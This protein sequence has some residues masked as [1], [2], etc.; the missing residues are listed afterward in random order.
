[1]LKHFFLL[2]ASLL[3]AMSNAF[4]FCG[5]F[6]AKSDGKMFNKSSQVILARNGNKT[7]ITM[8]QD[9]QGD[10]KDF[11]MVVPVPVVL[12]RNQ[13]RTVESYFIDILNNYSAPRVAEYRDDSPCERKVY[14]R[15]DTNKLMVASMSETRGG[16]A[17][18]DYKVKIE[19]SYE[20]DEYD[21]LILSAKE[22]DGL[23]RWLVDNGYKI[24][25]QAKE[26]LEPYIKS[27]MKFFVAK[28]SLDR[29]EEKGTDLTPLQISF[30][31]KKFMLPIRLGMANADGAQ[32]MQ[33][34]VINKGGRVETTNYQQREMKSNFNIPEFASYEFDNFYKSL[35]DKT[36]ENSDK[37]GIYVE[38][39]WDL[40]QQSGVKCDPCVSPPVSYD[41]LG[42]FG[43][44]WEVSNVFFT[45]LRVRYDRD[46]FPQD[47][48][49]QITPNK[50]RFQCR[51]V[52][53]RTSSGPFNCAAAKDYF[54]KV[55]D[56]RKLEVA[57]ME[58]YTS[59]KHTDFPVY[60]DYISR[61]EKR[62]GTKKNE[63]LPVVAP[64]P[65]K[66][67]GNSGLWITLLFS[68]IATVVV[69]GAFVKRSMMS[70]IP[71]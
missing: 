55:T 69:G 36:Y 64:T 25:E 32:N 49:F 62:I 4:P 23:Q 68:M 17:E 54:K 38:Y 33:V 1:M 45:R 18:R 7:T 44:D 8:A 35:F 21:I 50:E 11:A 57:N 60:D 67:P 43:M 6:V 24:P 66:G 41:V 12:K 14:L 53:H 63:V 10:I 37:K 2:S 61:W 3:L 40:S 31:S 46:H 28:V 52:I 16:I 42:E 51:Y 70:T 59:L 13:M 29:I 19:A 47:L 65:P 56:R 5:F 58:T 26:V 39:A 22:S 34:F 15:G 48:S 71:S 9:Y 20:V 30:N 27:G